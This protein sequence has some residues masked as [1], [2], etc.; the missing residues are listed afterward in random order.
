MCQYAIVVKRCALVQC[1]LKGEQGIGVNTAY[2]GRSLEA[3]GWM[4]A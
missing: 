1:E 2:I 3:G 4:C